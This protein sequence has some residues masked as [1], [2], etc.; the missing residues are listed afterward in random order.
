MELMPLAIALITGVSAIAV[1]WWQERSSARK[2]AEI[3]E[4]FGERMQSSD[5]IRSVVMKPAEGRW[6]YVAEF[7]RFFGIDAQDDND[8][9]KFISRGLASFQ[10]HSG[11]YQILLGY[12]NRDSDGNKVAAS[13]NVGVLR[14][15]EHGVIQ[16]GDEIQMRYLHRV[17]LKYRVDGNTIDARDPKEDAYVFEVTEVAFTETGA[18]REMQCVLRDH[19]TSG[20]LMRF[21]REF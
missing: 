15:C 14:S 21:T 1:V 6:S 5:A 10:W 7:D 13:V 20:G 11:V 3:L 9:T 17:G 4:R 19:A 12:S 2:I 18:I 8:S 16:R